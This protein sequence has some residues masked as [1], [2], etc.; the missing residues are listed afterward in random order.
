M[1][2]R[3]YES[4]WLVIGVAPDGTPMP[5]DAII[6]SAAEAVRGAEQSG[7]LAVSRSMLGEMPVNRLLEALTAVL[8]GLPGHGAVDAMPPRAYLRLLDPGV[9]PDWSDGTLCAF[10]AIADGEVSGAR[11]VMHP[12][13]TDADNVMV[14]T[15]VMLFLNALASLVGAHV[16]PDGTA[17]YFG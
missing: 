3:D 8:T 13:P 17:S 7:A 5:S 11:V 16:R 15:I 4:D 9:D 14:R 1:S 2:G 10:H 6:A 12:S